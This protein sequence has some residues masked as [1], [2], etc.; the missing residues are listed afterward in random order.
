MSWGREMKKK[1]VSIIVHIMKKL[2]EGKLCGGCAVKMFSQSYVATCC[3]SYAAT[4]QSYAAV[5]QSYAATFC[6]QSYAATCC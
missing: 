6:C 1:K 5:C 3:E 2:V 4:C